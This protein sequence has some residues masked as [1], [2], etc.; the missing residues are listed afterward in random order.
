M[1]AGEDS[2]SDHPIGFGRRI[3]YA[4]I[5][6]LAGNAAIAAYFLSTYLRALLQF[7]SSVAARPA[8]QILIGYAGLM[9]LYGTFSLIGW[10]VVG[11]PAVVLLPLRMINR[12]PWLVILLIA[13]AI[14]APPCSSSSFFSPAV[15]SHRTLLVPT[16]PA[17]LD[18]RSSRLNGRILHLLLAHPPPPQR[19]TKRPCT[20]PPLPCTLYS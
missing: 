1:P 9:L 11:L 10:L 6:L 7:H 19:V 4:F 12:L 20:L 8:S 14:G 13:A 15:T 16:L 3:G 5:G 18:P 17:L 2:A